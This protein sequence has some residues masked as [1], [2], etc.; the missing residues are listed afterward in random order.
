MKILLL[1]I[2]LMGITFI[3]KTESSFFSFSEVAVANI[4]V[5]ASILK[6][7]VVIHM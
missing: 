6:E 3:E 4:E 2:G 7:S 5:V 1:H